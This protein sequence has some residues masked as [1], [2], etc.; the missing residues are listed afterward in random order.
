MKA[1]IFPALGAAPEVRDD[2]PDPAPGDGEVLVRVRASSV[3]PVD[4][5]IAAGMLD[6]MAEHHFPV[7]LGRDYAGV[8]EAVGRGV[9]DFE[10]GGEVFGYVPHADPGVEKG[11]WAELIVV[12]EE[13]SIARVPEGVDLAAAGAAP[14]AA[15]TALL[16]LDALAL[17]SGD[18]LLVVG[19]AG[20][21]G[22][23][24]TQIAAR[25]G[26]SVIA[27]GLPED[28]GYLQGLGATAVPPRDADVAAA[29]RAEYPE[30]VSALLDVVSFTPDAFDAHAAALADGGRGASPVGAAG[31]GPGRSNVMATGSRENLERVAALLAGGLTVP[32]QETYPIADAPRALEALGTTHT[33][34]KLAI[35][36]G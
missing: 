14:L 21:V 35:S 20:G 16:A 33:Q 8:V 5:A 10:P 34:G 23:F 9:S 30:G 13:R 25:A 4:N 24:A 6:G 32:V 3:N 11:S 29:A 26:V 28:E 15:I 2:V 7:V 19:A 12:P 1:V 27:P 18:S 17:S 36:V 22:S 31:D